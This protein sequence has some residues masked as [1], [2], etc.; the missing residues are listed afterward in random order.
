M[1]ILI[2]N[3]PSVECSEYL[4]CRYIIYVDTRDYL[5][6]VPTIG[7]RQVFSQA[8]HSEDTGTEKIH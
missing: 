3:F 1:R 8:G 2:L 5:I 4:I 7:R 6:I